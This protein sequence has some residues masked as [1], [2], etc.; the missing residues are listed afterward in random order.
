MG[1]CPP[2]LADIDGD[3]DLDLVVGENGN[4]TIKIQALLNPLMKQKL[5]MTILLMA[6]MGIF[7]TN[8]VILTAMAT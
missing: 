2:T 7:P 6:L 8:L 4:N 1:Y 3:G 5:E